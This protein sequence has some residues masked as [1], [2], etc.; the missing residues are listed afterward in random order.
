MRGAINHDLF[1]LVNLPLSKSV[2]LI[3]LYS[4]IL[5][6][7]AWRGLLYTFFGDWVLIPYLCILY[8]DIRPHFVGGDMEY[9]L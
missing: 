2:L 1:A 6:R 3:A 5:I 7:F 4:V 8:P 9:I